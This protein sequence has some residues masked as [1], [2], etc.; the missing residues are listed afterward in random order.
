MQKDGKLLVDGLRLKS[1]RREYGLSQEALADACERQGLRVSIATIKRAETAKP[2]TY[3]TLNNI[4]K[5]FSIPANELTADSSDT[6]DPGDPEA[7][8]RL[9]ILSVIKVM[10]P[11]QMEGL[12]RSI[13]KMKPLF[14]EK[15]GS[16]LIA[17][18]NK[19]LRLD[20]ALL[21]GG[22]TK[23]L[24]I[25]E[26]MVRDLKNKSS[27]LSPFFCLVT[28]SSIKY[29]G[30]RYFLDNNLVTRLIDKS[31][32][33]PKNKL[34][35][36]YQLKSLYNLQFHF[37]MVPSAPSF[38]VLE[39][40]LIT[41]EQQIPMYGRDEQVK[42][43]EKQLVLSVREQRLTFS[44]IT[45]DPGMGNTR[46]L[47]ELERYARQVKMVPISFDAEQYET[48]WQA[49]LYRQAGLQ[50]EGNPA[51]SCSASESGTV[52]EYLSAGASGITLLID[53]LH[54]ADQGALDRL[55]TLIAELKALPIA[56]IVTCHPHCSDKI[57]Q[58]FQ[59]ELCVALSPLTPA[60]CQSLCQ[61]YSHHSK[62]W[63][64]NSVERSNGIPF[65]LNLLLEQ[66]HDAP[67]QLPDSIQLV[68]QE[69]VGALAPRELQALHLVATAAIT[70]T[71]TQLK[72]MLGYLPDIEHMLQL[73]VLQKT[74]SDQIR[75]SHDLIRE[76]VQQSFTPAQKRSLHNEVARHFEKAIPLPNQQ[77]SRW[78]YQQYKAANN[79]FR[80]AMHLGYHANVLLKSGHYSDAE[81][82]IFEALGTVR[83][84]ATPENCSVGTYTLAQCLDLELDL[85]FYLANIYKHRYGWYSPVITDLYQQI[86]QLCERT[87]SRHRKVNAL[88]GLWTIT[89]TGLDIPKA[90]EF[91]EQAL[92][93]SEQLED[94]AGMMHALTAL[95]NTSFWA[96]HSEDAYRQASQSL[97]HYSPDLL[98]ASLTLHGQDPRMLAW[99]FKV[100]AASQQRH[101]DAQSFLDEMLAVS[102]NVEHPFSLAI[103]LQ[104]GAWYYWQQRN[105]VQTLLYADEL[106]SLA[107]EHA[108]PFY[109]G[110]AS[111][112]SG[113]AAYQL[114][115]NAIHL[116]TVA[117]GYQRWLSSG[118]FKLTHSLYSV[119][120]ADILIAEG[121]QELATNVIQDGIAEAE[122]HQANC[123][124][125]ELYLLH[126]KT[127]DRPEYWCEKALQHPAC[128][129]LQAELVNDTRL[130]LF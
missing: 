67:V 121:Q 48:D 117:N 41:H 43:L 23:T 8:E 123:Y 55:Q 33:L 129:P 31:Q 124:I 50:I 111:L 76:V 59:P 101:P 15:S 85:L 126:A 88:F 100:L 14:V 98:E 58:Q 77:L 116:E 13:E 51:Q 18:F 11:S 63:L 16:Y 53:N 27:T 105:P 66:N 25:L 44:C 57:R 81:K 29:D 130:M 56:V 86:M 110:V 61:H 95:C 54:A 64:D 26:R 80:A 36:S 6:D 114:A 12:Y 4:S 125:P 21:E 1:L 40:A 91:G 24:Y 79:R 7:K 47:K 60:Q 94:P 122:L 82:E 37:V 42:R 104:A 9:C 72:N 113:W 115:P 90:L 92:S 22:Q 109:Q 118:G 49:L 32:T 10:N 70:M 120:I 99:C 112:F 108:L 5:F 128:T 78:L 34:V 62:A 93:L 73:K 3:R 52:A 68:I 84:A 89:L 102:R 107:T 28:L 30:N 74:S 96:G 45:G 2:V 75:V 103:A 20:D 127:G 38:W 17:A 106:Y 71:I 19:R 87:D 39:E 97:A 46:L 35:V 69:Q 119:L 65:F 83:E